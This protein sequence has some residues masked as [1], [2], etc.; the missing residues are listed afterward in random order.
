M[1]SQFK[2][3][4]LIVRI[5]IEALDSLYIQLHKDYLYDQ[6]RT[7]ELSINPVAVMP[8]YRV[9]ALHWIR[10]QSN[11]FSLKI[12]KSSPTFP[13]IDD[14]IKLSINQHQSLCKIEIQYLLRLLRRY[15]DSLKTIS[16]DSQNIGRRTIMPPSKCHSWVS[17]ALYPITYKSYV[18]E[19]GRLQNSQSTF[20]ITY[21]ACLKFIDWG[22]SV[23]VYDIRL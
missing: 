19:I 8:L 23:S 15:C 4:G 21:S 12:F 5:N 3:L 20:L 17:S 7:K 11:R 14:N 9:C 1:I 6:N 13:W 22:N 18:S 2:Q 10:I 16:I